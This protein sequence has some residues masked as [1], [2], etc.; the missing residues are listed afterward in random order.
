MFFALPAELSDRRDVALSQKLPS[1]CW[2]TESLR[3]Q[4]SDKPC[5]HARTQN[6]RQENSNVIR[7]AHRTTNPPPIHPETTEE[8]S[9]LIR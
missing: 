8:P 7:L 1:S 5:P 9:G 3:L 6:F 4:D 2:K